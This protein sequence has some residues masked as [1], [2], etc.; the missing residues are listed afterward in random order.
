[1]EIISDLLVHKLLFSPVFRMKKKLNFAESDADP[2]LDPDPDPFS[3]KRIR[4]S[5]SA[6]K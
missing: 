4:G 1:M 6:L 3:R 5:G 2:E